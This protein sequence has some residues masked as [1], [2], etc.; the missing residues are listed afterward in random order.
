MTERETTRL[1]PECEEEYL[2]EVREAGIRV[3]LEIYCPG[4][5]YTE[6]VDPESEYKDGDETKQLGDS[7]A[8]IDADRLS[9]EEEEY[10]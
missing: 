7:D 9:R 1:C 8:F 2:I 5:S 10:Y 3:P 4:C 6:D